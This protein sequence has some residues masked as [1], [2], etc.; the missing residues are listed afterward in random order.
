MEGIGVFWCIVEML[1]ENGGVLRLEYD[2]ITFELHVQNVG[3]I[4]SVI[5]DFGLFEIEGD[6]FYSTAVSER[7]KLMN[8]KSVKA[9][10]SINKR[11]GT[12]DKNTNV[13]RPE[14]DRNTIKVKESKVNKIKEEGEKEKKPPSWKEFYEAELQKTDDKDYHT[15]VAW[16]LGENE[17]SEPFTK[18]LSL[19]NQIGYAQFIKYKQLAK[20]N[21]TKIMDKIRV[22]ENKFSQ[23][24][25]TSLS[26]TLSDWLKKDF[27]SA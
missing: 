2:R 14:N 25:P 22:L 27:K 17:I 13:L 18:C 1:Y 21:G 11:W 15:F 20:E 16:L 8:E 3:I 9:R 12:D 23:Y 6:F 10:E 4:K 24:K 26:L 7:L 19:K 5:N